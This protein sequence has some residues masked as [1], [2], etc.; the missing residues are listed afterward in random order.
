MIIIHGNQT[1]KVPESYQRYL[2]NAF[3]KELDLVGTPLR[4]EFRTGDNP[5]KDRRNKLSPR[6]QQKRKR[7]VRH[8]KKG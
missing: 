5:Y 4:V 8:I 7:L 1:D 2:I 6:Q 3:R